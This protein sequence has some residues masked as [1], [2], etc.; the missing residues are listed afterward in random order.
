MIVRGRNPSLR[1]TFPVVNIAA[2]P[3]A[4]IPNSRVLTN[5]RED[6]TEPVK[7]GRPGEHAAGL[8]ELSTAGNLFQSLAY[9][10]RPRY[11][12]VR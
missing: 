1:N 7:L 4:L 12:V 10:E 11:S 3:I 6:R 2:D 5:S 8:V 9:S